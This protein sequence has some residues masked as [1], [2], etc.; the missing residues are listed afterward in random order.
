MEYCSSLSDSYF[1]EKKAD[2]GISPSDDRPGYWVT[3]GE[4]SRSQQLPV[5]PFTREV[6]ISNTYPS[7]HIIDLHLSFSWE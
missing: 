7:L 5:V 3:S 2:G 1:R 6:S 4:A